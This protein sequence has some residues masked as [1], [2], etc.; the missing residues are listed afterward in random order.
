M[1]VLSLTVVGLL[2]AGGAIEALT[3][4]LSPLLA[5][6]NISDVYV[7]PA[8]TNFLPVERRTMV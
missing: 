7:M 8:L 1:L 3:S 6:F 5:V 4:L 2:K